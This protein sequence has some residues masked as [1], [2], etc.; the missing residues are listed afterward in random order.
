MLTIT[1]LE[2]LFKHCF[3]KAFVRFFYVLKKCFLFHL[4][5]SFHSWDIRFLAIFSF[6]YFPN[7]KSQIKLERLQI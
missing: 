7:S 6:P 4:E 3:L 2:R 5:R 1:A